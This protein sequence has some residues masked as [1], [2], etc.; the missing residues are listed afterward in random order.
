MPFEV[1]RMWQLWMWTKGARECSSIESGE[2]SDDPGY[3]RTLSGLR[4]RVA[5][6]TKT[7][8][9]SQQIANLNAEGF[10]A[11]RLDRGVLE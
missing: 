2:H 10:V 4:A 5:Q 9:V 8:D 6:L 1:V 7:T 11:F 3:L